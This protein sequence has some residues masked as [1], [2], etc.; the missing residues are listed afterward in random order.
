MTAL[1]NVAVVLAV[2]AAVTSAVNASTGESPAAIRP[3]E[4]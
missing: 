1:Q 3:R 4:R 2:A